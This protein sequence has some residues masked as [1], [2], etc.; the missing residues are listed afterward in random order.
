MPRP[1]AQLIPRIGNRAAKEP[2]DQ[3]NDQQLDGYKKPSLGTAG[4]IFVH[5]HVPAPIVTSAAVL[6]KRPGML[7]Y[8]CRDNDNHL[9]HGRL[10]DASPGRKPCTHS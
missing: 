10:G 2:Y 6:F 4:L 5:R 9:W 8:V 7:A 3:D 1:F